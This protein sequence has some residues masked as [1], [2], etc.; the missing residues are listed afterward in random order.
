M[1]ALVGCILMSQAL[2]PAKC[3]LRDTLGV[4]IR[5]ILPTIA[6]SAMQVRQPTVT[7][8]NQS[9]TTVLEVNICQKSLEA[10]IGVFTAK[11]PLNWAQFHAQDVLQVI[12]AQ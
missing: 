7:V 10:W 12:S 4:K 9:V 11:E 1:S 8:V 5:A 6:L 3:A 2:K